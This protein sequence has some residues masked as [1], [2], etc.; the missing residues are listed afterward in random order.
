MDS[1]ALGGLTQGAAFSVSPNSR[2]REDKEQIVISR[3]PQ[4][5]TSKAANIGAVRPCLVEG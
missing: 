3:G 1:L 5:A 2:A 4:W